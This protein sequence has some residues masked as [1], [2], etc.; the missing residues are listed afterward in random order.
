MFKK[1]VIHQHDRPFSIKVLMGYIVFLIAFYLLYL[2]MELSSP[3]TILFGKIVTG[4]NALLIDIG[5]LAAL[6]AMLVGFVKK[7]SWTFYLALLWFAGGIINALFSIAFIES[8]LFFLVK[9]L[10]VLS[11]TSVILVNGLII[12]YLLYRKE[13]FMH[14]PVSYEGKDKF[15]V[16]A[17]LSFW[18]IIILIGVTIG[19][20]YYDYTTSTTK[21][22]LAEVNGLDL[23]SATYVC[24]SKDGYEKDL[25]FVVLAVSHSNGIEDAED[26][27]S[28]VQT[29]F[30][31]ITCL[32]AAGG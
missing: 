8:G 26:F 5:V 1:K 6:V 24:D 31:K 13:Y 20:K 14:G 30:Y 2:I 21:E 17:L 16:Y 29:G 7:R 23:N 10:I 18:L 25:C 28:K 12:W 11:F 9:D 32:R 4:Q 15:F 22:L 3:A 27:C 19:F